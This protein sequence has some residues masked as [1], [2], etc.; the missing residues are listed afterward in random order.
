M[1]QNEDVYAIGCRPEVAGEVISGRNVKTI[2]GHTALNLEIATI[3]SFREIH[4]QPF[5]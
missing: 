4:N 1:T 3:S 5:V 2:E